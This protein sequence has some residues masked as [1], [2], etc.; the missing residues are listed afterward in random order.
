MSAVSEQRLTKRLLG[1]WE[2]LQKD[3]IIPQIERFN[4]A[5]VEDIWHQCITLS[6]DTRRAT[7]FKIEN[8]GSHI[9]AIHGNDI[10]GNIVDAATMM[11]P[12]SAMHKQ[13]LGVVASAHYQKADGMFLNEK[14]EMVKYRACY[15]PFGSEQKGVTH[16][17]VG[18]AFSAF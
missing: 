9:V 1:Y 13:L 7:I 16:I 17:I 10:S 12:G 11:F 6:V 4:S 8:M 3:K 18:L 5:A 14:S 2:I 15:L